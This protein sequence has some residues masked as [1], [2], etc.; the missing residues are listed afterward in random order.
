[1]SRPLP[2]FVRWGVICALWVPL[3]A[4]GFLA[5]ITNG[6]ASGLTSVVEALRDLIEAVERA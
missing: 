1:M 4:I 3:V 5:W 6:A 2:G